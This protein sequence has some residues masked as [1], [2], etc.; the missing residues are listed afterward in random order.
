M[1][2]S[3]WVELAD[4]P[5]LTETRSGPLNGESSLEN[6][7]RKT[8]KN[9]CNETWLNWWNSEVK[10]ATEGS[11]KWGTRTKQFSYPNPNS[12]TLILTWTLT[13]K[14]LTS[15]K[16]HLGPAPLA[17]IILASQLSFGNMEYK[18][19]IFSSFLSITTDVWCRS[20]PTDR[21]F[22]KLDT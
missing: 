13:L 4:L 2:T 19:L 10:V 1:L 6:Q 5:I 14:S 20:H 21:P 18:L 11:I 8:N 16:C 9:Q 7:T 22:P 17:V 3:F 12:I 15:F